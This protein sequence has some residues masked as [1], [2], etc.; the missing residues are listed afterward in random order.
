GAPDYVPA[1]CD[2]R[3]FSE[4]GADPS[5]P[6]H[7]DMT[8]GNFSINALSQAISQIRGRALGCTFSLPEPPVG[9]TIDPGEVNVSVTVDGNATS[10]P[11]RGDS[12]DSCETDGCWD[13][14]AD[15]D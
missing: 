4:S 12:S 3:M 15:G 6:C 2:G 8:Q 9:E 5:V 11:R 10:V 1:D 7:F 13:Y 14:N